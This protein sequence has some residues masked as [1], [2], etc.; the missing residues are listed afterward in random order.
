MT[1]PKCCG[2][3]M[4]E[5]FPGYFKCSICSETY[6]IRNEQADEQDF[7]LGEYYPDNEEEDYIDEK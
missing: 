6:D 5:I 1:G 3:K 7:Y 2:L 4:R